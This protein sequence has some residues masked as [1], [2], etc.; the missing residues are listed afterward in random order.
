MSMAIIGKYSKGFPLELF[1]R[2][3]EWSENRENARLIRKEVEGDT[4]EIPR[5]LTGSDYLYLQ[6]NFTV[7]DSIFLDENIIF[8]RVTPEWIDFCVNELGIK[9]PK[10]DPGEAEEG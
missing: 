2:F 5:E 9:F 7:T 10:I 3:P 1:R 6:E 4:V 8:N